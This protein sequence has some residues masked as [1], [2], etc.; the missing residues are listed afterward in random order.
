[1]AWRCEE[2]GGGGRVGGIVAGGEVRDR[3]LRRSRLH[4]GGK[5]TPVGCPQV[6]PLAVCTLEVAS[7]RRSR[8]G[9]IQRLSLSIRVVPDDG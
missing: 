4:P 1:M 6:I 8:Y 9:S 5:E 7:L 2:S 3:G